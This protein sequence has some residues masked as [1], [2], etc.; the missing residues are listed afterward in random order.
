MVFGNPQ[1]LWLLAA[2]LL[3]AW[4]GWRAERGRVRIAQRIGRPALLDRLYPSSVG[5]W[6]SRRLL[7]Y[8]LA[9][10]LLIVAAA[11]PQYG[12]V[13]QTLQSVGTHVIVALD[14][15]P[16]MM[17]EDV[18]PNRL[19]KA[20]QSL[21]LMLRRLE[22]NRVGIIAFAGVAFL[23]CPMT[24][25]HGMAALVL[26][27]IAPDSIGVAG[28]DLGAAVSTAIQAFD[29][30]AGDG[31]RALILITDGEDHEGKLD[32][33]ADEAAAQGVVIYAI[34][35]GTARGAPIAKE[36][37]GFK[38]D[39]TGAK[40]NTQLQMS[41]LQ[42]L[43]QVTGGAAYEAGDNPSAAIRAIVKRIEQQER[44]ELAVRRHVIHQDRFQWFLVPA[45]ALL[46]WAMLLRPEPTR[47]ETS[48]AQSPA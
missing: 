31:G 48:A 24:L 30:G 25:D 12:E 27:S 21:K 36:K 20:K 46:L 5:R 13:E 41:S 38:E 10:L 37:G 7:L 47:H 19:E 43:A 45:L 16:S 40:V 3:V 39:Q 28:T 44:I 17:A 14:C 4:L 42:K 26:Q 9:L 35:I 18:Q 6:R 22:G 34:G 32:E 2:W 23:Q 8:L 15:S 1:A 29:R 33:A 11:R